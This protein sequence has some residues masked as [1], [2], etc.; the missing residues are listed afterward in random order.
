MTVGALAL[1][2]WTFDIAVLR[3]V[4]P[5][6]V[7]MYPNPAICFIL[8][9]VALW[10]SPKQSVQSKNT[11][12]KRQVVAQ[13]CSLFASL[14]GAV[15]LSEDLFGFNAGI[16]RLLFQKQ[17][18]ELLTSK[19]PYPG[20]MPQ[21]SALLF[22]LFGTA[23]VL[24]NAKSR[25]GQRL[26]Q[27]FALVGFALGLLPLL[28]YGYAAKAVY[29]VS[30]FPAL[31]GSLVFLALAVAILCA[32][33]DQGLISTVTSTHLG[34]LF[35]RRILPV[36]IT[37]PFLIGWLWLLG[38]HAGLYE[39]EFGLAISTTTNVLI[40]AAL[41]W[42]GSRSLN[43]VDAERQRIA[44]ELQVSNERLLERQGDL[45]EAQ[46][47]AHVG[48]WQWIAQTDAFTCS[49]EFRRI[50]GRDP[51]EPAPHYKD[52]PQLFTPESWASLEPAIRRTLRTGKPHDL[53]LE[54]VRADGTRRWITV[55]GEAMG[56]AAEE[57]VGLRG[58]SQDITE[59]KQNEAKLHKQA[60]LL[61]LAND[62][63]FAV[64][65]NDHITY[66]NLGAQRRYG[67]GQEET[68]GKHAHAFLQTVFPRPVEEIKAILLKEGYWEGEL[69][70]ATRDGSRITVA[71]RWSL[72]RDEHGIPAGFLE[73]NNDITERKQAEEALLEREAE[74]R[75]AQRITKVGNWKLAGETVTWSEELHRIFGR[76]PGLPAPSFSEQTA[77]I[78]PESW[79]RL[80]VAIERATKIGIPFELD[81]EI[82]CPDG[83]HKWIIARGEAVRDEE[84]RVTALRG[85]AQD[86]TERLGAEE[87]LRQ[88][89]E[90]FRTMANSIPQLA[91]IAQADGYIYWYNQRW[92]EYTETT[93]EQ[94]EGWGWQSVH[95][96]LVLPKVLEQW[97]ASIA[98]GEPF[99][100][101]FPLRGADGRFPTLPDPRVAPQ[102]CR[103]TRRS[104][105]WNQHGYHRTLGRREQTARARGRAKRCATSSQSGWLEMGSAD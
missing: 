97:R 58:T 104:V 15:T 6:F 47:V 40:F 66:W 83:T 37:T 21:V 23:L 103:G 95:D 8:L 35:A 99:D 90:R 5:G 12:L 41:V 31:N 65:R 7:P 27:N 44:A 46:R 70:H 39:T 26:A 71:S 73:V 63:I 45:E 57:I 82:V 86:I 51:E 77:I 38:G 34:G 19:D 93:P 59:R 54:I 81:L 67:W 2:G 18:L 28:G 48:S 22:V 61:D 96:P 89:E 29:R 78:T 76:D 62:A 16:D 79:A 74:L 49:E 98:T 53:D 92:Y 10:L 88:S 101:E 80:Q 87:R 100:M 91:W 55:R 17:L 36:A 94:M 32:R 75:E 14:V 105:V 42:F 30:F 56:N 24:L 85:T 72:Q 64:D 11:D 52:G 3:S 1:V 84:G 9:G 43:M 4:L 20:R 25:R 68:L 102:G 13:G 50:C 69:N 33:P 60:K